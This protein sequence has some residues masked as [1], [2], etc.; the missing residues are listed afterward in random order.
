[1]V[2]RWRCDSPLEVIEGAVPDILRDLFVK[3]IDSLDIDERAV[4]AAA[5]AVGLEFTSV[6]VAIAGELDVA[7]VR[8]ILDGLGGRGR[9]LR[10]SVDASHRTARAS[11]YRFRH[12]LY[13]D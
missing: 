9:V 13:A 8:R 10:S 1:T 5:C 3:E 2:G 11:A 4:L 12:P 7:R 6:P